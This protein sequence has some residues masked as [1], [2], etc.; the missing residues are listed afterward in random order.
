MLRLGTLLSFAL[1]ALGQVPDRHRPAYVAIET[2]PGGDL[3]GTLTV[4]A[5]T[6]P[7]TLKEAFAHAIGCKTATFEKSHYESQIVARCPP[8]RPSRLSFRA[9]VRLAELAPL[10]SQ[11]EATRLDLS[12][13]TFH[14][15]SVRLDPA[16]AS[17]GANGYYQEHYSL[18]QLPQQITIDGG[19]EIDQVRALG[20]AALGLI[21]TPF[22]LLLFRPSDPL[23]LRVQLEGIFVLGWIG[24]I[25][26][27]MRVEAGA[28]LNYVLH[29]RPLAPL[30][31]LMAPP[32]LVVWVGSRLAAFRYARLMPDGLSVEYYRRILFWSG[33]AATCVASTFLSILLMTFENA[34]SSLVLALVLAI[35]CVLRI[36]SIGRGG[37]HPLADGDLRKRIFE[38]AARAGV[39]LR[40]VSILTSPTPR[41]PAA[42]A[43]RW[44]L[45]L[46]NQGLLRSLSRR[47]VDAV[48]CHELSHIGPVKQTAMAWIYGLLVVSILASQWVPHF[49]D[50][51]PIPAL[52]I[53]L[54]IKF[55]R[56]G[57]ERKADLDSVRW[58]SDPEALITG[59]ARVSLA[60]GMPLEWTAPVSW[61]TA[62]P[63]TMERLRAIAH[64]G[65]LPDSRLAELL[66]ESRLE[67]ADHYKEAEVA[68]G[69]A[70]GA[71]F[72]PALRQRLQTRLTWF[73]LLAP[74]V[75]GL[76]PAWLLDRIGF[77]WWEVLVFGCLA[78][79]LAM[80]F[81]TEWIT[82]STR[83]AV[84]RRAIAQHG[85]GMFVGFSPAPE[86]RLFDGSYQYDLGILRFENGALE[87][88][89][90]RTRFALDRTL[91][92]RVWLG[93]GPRHWTP[94][95][96]VY[97]ECRPAS[98][99]ALVTFSLQSLEAWFWPSTAA[100]AKR[101]HR[102]VEEW[103]TA[104]SSSSEPAL[105]CDLPRVEGNPD[106]SIPFR[107]AYRSASIYC[108]VAFFLVSIGSGFAS[109]ASFTDPFEMLCPVAVCGVLSLFLLWPRLP[110]SR[111]KALPGSESRL[112]ADS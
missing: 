49:V 78:G 19:F 87:F 107:T 101:L 68:S 44:G 109:P 28:L 88:A 26:V 37:S 6:P 1:I 53:Y 83:D 16:L 36:R 7:P 58:S 51:I 41:P 30:L 72:S 48:V 46:L 112:P 103:H 93:D 55:W 9:T 43:A 17:Q 90:D 110:W 47:E 76:P 100:M 52:T 111:L 66:E 85:Q 98:E 34:P 22:L 42:F 60:N 84:K 62:H 99:S 50:F 5:A 73:G 106:T 56:R 108:G 96:V 11:A 70:E 86:P 104:S 77:A 13:I 64:A 4:P 27:L 3:R 20:A 2:T 12:L 24:W 18:D 67:T 95:R 94:R 80:I 14:F 31:I 71:A 102:K 92:Q 8:D 23:R 63:P 40:N 21:L 45:I 10:L 54:L 35:A 59:L 97:I 91:V 38:L 81:G 57:E 25:W 29:Q 65:R 32:L 15:R 79:M 82:G 74:I 105:L 69:I 33:A 89:G 61:M 39:K 75:L